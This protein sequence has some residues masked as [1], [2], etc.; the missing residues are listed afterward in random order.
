MAGNLLIPFYLSGILKAGFDS[1]TPPSGNGCPKPN[2]QGES[3]P[4]STCLRDNNQYAMT[5]NCGYLPEVINSQ[6]VKIEE[7]TSG[8]GYTICGNQLNNC[9]TTIDTVSGKAV[10]GWKPPAEASRFKFVGVS[11]PISETLSSVGQL[12]VSGNKLYIIQLGNQC[13]EAN[14]VDTNLTLA[15]C[16][17]ANPDDTATFKQLFI[18]P[19][20]SGKIREDLDV[21]SNPNG[22]GTSTGNGNGTSTGN[23][24]GAS[25]GNGNGASTGNEVLNDATKLGWSMSVL[26]SLFL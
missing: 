20:S 7:A 13:L 2:T 9:L 24:N 17:Q 22:N 10:M 1:T 12:Q 3:I 21:T 23:G 8:A 19:D 16:V 11:Q 15:D 14:G 6:V 26:I 5:F 25:T 4:C 18:V